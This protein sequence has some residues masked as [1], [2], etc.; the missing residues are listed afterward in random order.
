MALV[1]NFLLF[2]YA[3]VQRG[4]LSSQQPPPPGFKRFSCLGLL[5]SWDHRHLPPHPANFCIFSRDG[6]QSCSGTQPGLQWCDHSSLQPPTP[7]LKR[8]SCLSLPKCWADR[9]PTEYDWQFQA[10]I[11]HSLVTVFMTQRRGIT[12]SPRL[13]FSGAIIAHCNLELLGS[14]DLPNSAF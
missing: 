10:I 4:D 5:S 8:S 11:S 7:G 6:R 3:S 2:D 9:I 12:L 1:E 14:G 13:E